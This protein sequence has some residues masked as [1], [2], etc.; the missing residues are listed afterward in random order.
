MTAFYQSFVEQKNKIAQDIAKGYCGG[1]YSESAL[2]LCSL[3][4]A[5]SAI[6]WPG[7][8]GIDMKRFVEIITKFPPQGINPAKVRVP[9][10]LQTCQISNCRLALSNKAFYLTEDI[11]RDE[12]E[13]IK[14]CPELSL[15]QI[16][17]FS[18]A[19]LLYQQLRNGYA[20]NYM[21]GEAASESDSLRHIANLN[22]TCVF[23]VNVVRNNSMFRIIY[24]PFKWIACVAE[25]IATGLD[26]EASRGGKKPFEEIGI[27][28]PNRWWI[29]G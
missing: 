14:L 23:Y 1:T 29:D 16:R 17:R 20:H 12:A 2:I 22:E 9:L 15:K 26:Y 13:V 27:T 5:M 28:R 6:A 21:I 3:I 25:R 24:F 19:Y 11:D 8:D 7:R 18:Y 10:L 4:S